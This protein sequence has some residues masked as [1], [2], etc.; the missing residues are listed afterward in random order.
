M[1]SMTRKSRSNNFSLSYVYANLARLDSAGECRRSL[2]ELWRTGED[3][4]LSTSEAS[5]SVSRSF[6]CGEIF[7]HGPA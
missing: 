3:A 6:D 5:G 1:W 4:R 2:P 7:C